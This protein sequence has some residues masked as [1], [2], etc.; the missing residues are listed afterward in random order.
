MDAEPAEGN[1]L[2]VKPGSFAIG[3]RAALLAEPARPP[4]VYAYSPSLTLMVAPAL[5]SAARSVPI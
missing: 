5:S 2:A 3:G 1:S 4:A